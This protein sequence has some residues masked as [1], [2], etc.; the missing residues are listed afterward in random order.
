MKKLI[1]SILMAGLMLSAHY[2]EAINVLT[3]SI[4]NAVTA[5]NN[6]YTG[7]ARV[8]QI[9]VLSATANS[10][11]FY[12]T[13]NTALTVVVGSYTNATNV[14]VSITNLTTNAIFVYPTST[15][16]LI[17]TN[18]YVN[19]N[20]QSNNLVAAS[21]NAIPAAFAVDT[22]ANLPASAENLDLVFVKGITL[23]STNAV[24]VIIYTR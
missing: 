5:T 7:S 24:D 8:L 19:A 13:T 17:Q 22:F 21:T 14:T 4:T 3:Y 9:S 23:K 15:Q 12:D 1:A 11:K 18:I 10:L 16:Y 6:L 20:W 2:A